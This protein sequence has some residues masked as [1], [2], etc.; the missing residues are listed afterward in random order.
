MCLNFSQL[1][2]QLIDCFSKDDT[3]GIFFRGNPKKTGTE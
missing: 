1:I 3:D 2:D